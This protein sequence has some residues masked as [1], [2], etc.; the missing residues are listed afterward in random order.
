MLQINVDPISNREEWTD[1]C[2]VRDQNNV[3]V[4]LSSASI[5]LAVQ[6]RQTKVHVLLAS[7]DDGNITIPGTGVFR[8]TF[9]ETEMRGVDASRAYEIG[10]TLALNGT[11]HQ[12]FIGTVN[13]LDGIVP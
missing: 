12:L 8:W 6:D 9:T 7:T 2:E 13:V 5:V 3:L 10:C 4:D 1:N 11:I